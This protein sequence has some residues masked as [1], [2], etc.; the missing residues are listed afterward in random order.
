MYITRSVED[1]QNAKED[2][3]ITNPIDDSSQLRR[4]P[5]MI[6]SKAVSKDVVSHLACL[7]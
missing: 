6:Q 2:E 7:R 1:G 5:A 4:F 3:G